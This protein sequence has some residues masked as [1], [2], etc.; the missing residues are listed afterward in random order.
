MSSVRGYKEGL[1]M[2]DTGYL[3]SVE[4]SRPLYEKTTGLIFIDHGGAFPFKGNDEVIDSSDFLTSFGVGITHNF[5]SEHM[6][7]LVLGLPLQHGNENSP[8][9]HFVWQSVL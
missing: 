5:S 7:K 9:L 1:L 2:G 6:A 3:L 8:R 4:W